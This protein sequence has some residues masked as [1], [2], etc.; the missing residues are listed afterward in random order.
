MQARLAHWAETAASDT[1][2]TE[3]LYQA[4]LQADM[5]GQL[6]VR[7]VEVPE[8]TSDR[9]LAA[10]TSRNAF[11]SM[12]FDEAIEYFRSRDLLSPEAFAALTDAAKMQA[13]TASQLAT[14]RL[15]AFA[16]HKLYESLDRGGT[17]ERFAAQLRSEEVSLGV[18][19]SDPYYVENVY[20]T[21]VATAY[22]AGRY[23]QITSPAVQAARSLVEYRTAGDARVRPNHARLNGLVFRQSDPRWPMFAPPNGYQ[24]RCSIVLRRTSD[25]DPRR[26]VDAA[27]LG[28]EYLPDPGFRAAPTT[29][30]T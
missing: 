25:V 30:T 17:L 6:F 14:E 26:I 3:S 12:P 23:R 5:A 7:T 2:I 18:T 20:R 28:P 24:C 16:Q 4:S 29:G 22:G 27:T 9:A 8:A 19:P 1:A 10:P 15:R 21:N 11:L 13:F